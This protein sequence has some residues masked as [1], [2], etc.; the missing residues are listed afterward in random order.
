MVPSS[1]NGAPL[2]F[3]R[4][5]LP[6]S[7]PDPIETAGVG[8]TAT[9]LPPAAPPEDAGAVELEAE[10]PL[11]VVLE[12]EDEVSL[13]LE[14]LGEVEVD[15][16]AADGDELPPQPVSSRASAADGTRTRQI[17]RFM[18][19]PPSGD[20]ASVDA[21]DVLAMCSFVRNVKSSANP[22]VNRNVWRPQV[23]LAVSCRAP[24]PGAAP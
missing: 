8:S 24:I 17:E 11:S 2:T 20:E 3:A 1:P 9:A 19:F 22:P 18:V 10:E 16:D 4:L 13:V 21:R 23:T 14:E 6:L 5:A 12:A 7:A 15:V